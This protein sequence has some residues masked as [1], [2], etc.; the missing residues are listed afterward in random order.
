MRP[1]ALIYNRGDVNLPLH[2][3]SLA[4]PHGLNVSL[5]AYYGSNLGRQV[6]TWNR[7]APTGIMGLGWSLPFD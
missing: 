1:R 3:V 7:E 5:S 2:L 4:G 6:S